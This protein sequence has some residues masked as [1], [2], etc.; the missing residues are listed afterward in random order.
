[1][2]KIIDEFDKIYN[3]ARQEMNESG[4]G[5]TIFDEES[6]RLFNALDEEFHNAP[7]VTAKFKAA[8]K[9][10]DFLTSQEVNHPNIGFS[11]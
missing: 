6:R 10:V 7:N 5:F 11:D 8:K 3:I 2:Y 4:S 9:M 1:M